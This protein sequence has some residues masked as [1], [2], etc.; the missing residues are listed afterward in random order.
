M[1]QE[2]IELIET[3]RELK[4]NEQNIEDQI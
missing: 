4:S 2:F 1:R 3:E